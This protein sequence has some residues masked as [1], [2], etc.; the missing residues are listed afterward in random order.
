M[1]MTVQNTLSAENTWVV[2][3][4]LGK[5]NVSVSGTFSATV[6]IQRKFSGDSDWRDVDSF[7]ATAERNGV[8][9]EDNVQYRVGIKTGDYSSGIVDARLGLA[10]R[11]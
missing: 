11:S 5:F 10:K 4:I 6:T 8:E 1:G 3:A 9:L 7:T 2:L